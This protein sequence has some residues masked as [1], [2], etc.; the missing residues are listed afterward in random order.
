MPDDMLHESF[1]PLREAYKKAPTMVRR[2]EVARTRV[3]L[4]IPP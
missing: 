3:E 1:A 4:V 2:G